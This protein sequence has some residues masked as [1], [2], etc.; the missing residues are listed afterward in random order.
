MHTG[1]AVFEGDEADVRE[2]LDG[3]GHVIVPVGDRI[4]AW[5]L[6]DLD[7]FTELF[8]YGF[9]DLVEGMRGSGSGVEGPRAAVEQAA[10]GERGDV[11]HVVLAPRFL[12]PPNH[13]ILAPFFA[14]RGKGVG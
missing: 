6:D 12:A 11:V 4:G 14:S 8:G 5:R 13:G 7:G 2:R 3:V 10:Q 1:Y 9:G